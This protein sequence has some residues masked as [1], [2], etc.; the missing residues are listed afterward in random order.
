MYMEG[1]GS[2]LLIG[3]LIATLLGLLIGGVVY[4]AVKRSEANTR[5]SPTKE[6]SL[7]GPPESASRIRPIVLAAAGF[8]LTLFIV[9]YILFYLDW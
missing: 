5:S 6:T 7:Q 4:R 1:I 9:L 8:L 2:A 3:L